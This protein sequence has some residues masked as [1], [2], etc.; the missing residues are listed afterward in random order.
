MKKSP[1]LGFFHNEGLLLVNSLA[2]ANHRK[3]DGTRGFDSPEQ[4]YALFDPFGAHRAEDGSRHVA[5]L[6]EVGS[7]AAV[8][9]EHDQEELRGELDL[10]AKG[11]KHLYA[12]LAKE[13]DQRT[14]QKGA[15]L[16]LSTARGQIDLQL[17]G[18]EAGYFLAL[19]LLLDQVRRGAI[20]LRQCPLE[21]CGNFHIP[22]SKGGKYSNFCTPAH[23]MADRRLK[24]KE[25]SKRRREVARK[26]KLALGKSNMKWRTL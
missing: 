18:V 19:A 7:A 26:K 6:L 16:L 5:R 23:R 13:L 4:V 22:Q 3:A 14:A 8:I 1:S 15:T 17:Y 20:R 21:T 9:F 10:I 12:Q 24:S 11:S 25:R 2:F